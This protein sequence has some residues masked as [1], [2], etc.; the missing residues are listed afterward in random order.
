MKLDPWGH[1]LE[2]ASQQQVYGFL[3]YRTC[4][5]CIVT[6]SCLLKQCRMIACFKQNNCSLK[7]YNYLLKQYNYFLKQYN[8]LLK[9]YNCL[10]LALPRQVGPLPSWPTIKSAHPYRLH[11]QVGPPQCQPTMLSTSYFVT[12][13]DIG[14]CCPQTPALAVHT[15]QINYILVISGRLVMIRWQADM[16]NR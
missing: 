1:K 10:L 11:R 5:V 16:S 15:F 2:A 9:Q 3:K 4:I 6:I 14:G 12:F 8:C 7:Q 13:W